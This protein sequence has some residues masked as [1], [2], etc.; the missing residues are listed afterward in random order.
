[1]I[2]L[3]DMR[4]AAGVK[5]SAQVEESGRPRGSFIHAKRQVVKDHALA[6]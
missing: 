3:K 4:S 6:L 5:Q 1:M 2:L